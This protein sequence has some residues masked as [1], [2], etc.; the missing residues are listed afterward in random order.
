MDTASR[1]QL[2]RSDWT[3]DGRSSQHL[4]KLLL[5]SELCSV[6]LL[7]SHSPT[8]SF[9]ATSHTNHPNTSFKATSHTNH[10]NTSFNSSERTISHR[11]DPPNEPRPFQMDPNYQMDPTNVSILMSFNAGDQPE[12]PPVDQ[13]NNFPMDQQDASQETQS[14]Q[15]QPHGIDAPQMQWNQGHASHSYGTQNQ[16]LAVPVPEMAQPYQA[17]S[18]GPDV[19]Q[20][21]WNQGHASSSY[22][23]QTQH[24]AVAVPE[25][26]Q[27]YQASSRGPNVS[28]IQWGQGHAS[29]SYATQTHQLA[30]PMAQMEQRHQAPSQGPNAVP[31]HMNQ[32]SA[33][34]PNV[35]QY[36]QYAIPKAQMKQQYPAPLHVTNAGPMYISQGY[37]SLPHI[38]QTQNLAVAV[39]Q[40]NTQQYFQPQIVP[41]P[42]PGSA[43]LSPELY[44]VQAL[45]ALGAN[46]YITPV[47]S[48]RQ[49]YGKTPGPARDGQWTKW[50]IRQVTDTLNAF[51]TTHSLT[52]L[53]MY[54]IIS[55][56]PQLK[57]TMGQINPSL[58]NT[59]QGGKDAW[60][61]ILRLVQQSVPL[62]N[63]N[64]KS[65]RT[66][67]AKIQKT[68]MG[69]RTGITASLLQ[70]IRHNCAAA[71]DDRDMIAIR[72]ALLSHPTLSEEE[73][74]AVHGDE[75]HNVLYRQI[76]NTM[77]GRAGKWTDQEHLFLLETVQEYLGTQE[78][79][80]TPKTVKEIDWNKI[81]ETFS[82]RSERS[83]RRRFIHLQTQWEQWRD[84]PLDAKV[85][86]YGDEIMNILSYLL[87]PPSTYG[88]QQQNFDDGFLLDGFTDANLTAS[89]MSAPVVQGAMAQPIPTANPDSTLVNQAVQPAVSGNDIQNN[90][91]MEGMLSSFK[92]SAGFHMSNDNMI[93][94]FEIMPPLDECAALTSQD[95]RVI[96]QQVFDY[97][98][99]FE[100]SDFRMM[101]DLA[102]WELFGGYW[103]N[104]TTWSNRA[105]HMTISKVMNENKFEWTYD[106]PFPDALGR[107][108]SILPDA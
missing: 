59:P 68:F 1:L 23:T 42:V 105:R 81:E 10:P 91:S 72:T 60:L 17:S 28:Q 18:R 89:I 78:S 11:D 53:E 26:A 50:E 12:L 31:V 34:L 92:F 20:I 70:W 94:E 85:Q 7:Q 101:Q 58:A 88:I 97:A 30:L 54:R 41:Q 40:Q 86:P 51:M 29:S 103:R 46:H 65:R 45:S 44:D 22:A 73:K 15:A 3:V 8:Q 96:C 16:Q 49:I 99:R 43:D 56:L 2:T 9:K 90:A 98:S 80:G 102:A 19:S 71:V 69:P 95:I 35:A 62:R 33:P 38:S 55:C 64:I 36:Q 14:D 39:G 79:H 84:D 48:N 74:L 21:Q 52:T 37:P 93:H 77:A 76:A 67:Q 25:M 13:Q 106:M 4:L 87:E 61:V 32:G 66:M 5:L 47:S 83:S 107:V 100:I 75:I 63:A 24:L 104:G 27:P 6:N 57:R 108:I 82:H